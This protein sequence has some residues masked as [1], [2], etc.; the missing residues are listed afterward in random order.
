VLSDLHPDGLISHSRFYGPRVAP[1]PVGF[2]CELLIARSVEMWSKRSRQA[3]Q[4]QT[5][6]S[7]GDGASRM[8][9]LALRKV[10]LPLTAYAATAYYICTSRRTTLIE[11]QDYKL[12]NLS[13]CILDPRVRRGRRSDARVHRACGVVGDC[14]A[15]GA[16]H[17]DSSDIRLKCQVHPSLASGAAEN[18]FLVQFGCAKYAQKGGAATA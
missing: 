10:C 18:R 11:D 6:A 3:G 13:D 4:R 1:G 12:P 7:G 5:L 9:A 15:V 17:G 8:S 2:H 16:G 14:R